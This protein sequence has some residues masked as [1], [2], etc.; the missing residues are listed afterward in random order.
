MDLQQECD[1]GICSPPHWEAIW[2][3]HARSA[4][5]RTADGKAQAISGAPPIRSMRTNT[6]TLARRFTVAV[7]HTR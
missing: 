5:V 2:R 7:Y 3:Q 1:A 4:G 6:P